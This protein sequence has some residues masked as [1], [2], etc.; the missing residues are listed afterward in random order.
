MGSI[1]D[2][3]ERK[4]LED[5]E[6]RHTEALA[7]HARLN[8]LGLI[9]SELA[10]ELNQP[11]AALAG[12][13]TGLKLALRKGTTVDDEV[14]AAVEALQRN[15]TNAGDIV[16]WIRRQGARAEP[17]RATMRPERAGRRGAAS[18]GAD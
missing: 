12:Y 8:D 6:R 15:A 17:V 2:I 16:N 4:R 10:H 3:G 5:L 11:L 14:L 9:A 13:S 18:R 7:Q 1:V